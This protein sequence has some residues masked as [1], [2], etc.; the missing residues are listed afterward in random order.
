[1]SKSGRRKRQ[2]RQLAA[3]LERASTRPCLL[4]GCKADL[5]GLWMPSRPILDRML[6]PD[7]KSRVVAYSLCESCGSLPDYLVRVEARILAD[8][9]RLSMC[10]ARN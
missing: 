4:C 2:L 6:C 3:G 7:D 1:M 8:T 9:D 5:G 10:V